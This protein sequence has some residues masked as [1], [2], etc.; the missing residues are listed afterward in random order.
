MNEEELENAIYLV[1]C[2]K[3]DLPQALSKTV[4][5]V[6]KFFVNLTWK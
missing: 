2:N 1:L 4:Q 3:Q 5:V 6:S